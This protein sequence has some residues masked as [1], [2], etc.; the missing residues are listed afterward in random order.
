MHASKLAG[1]RQSLTTTTT[2]TKQQ[3]FN[4]NN[5]AESQRVRE[6]KQR[7]VTIAVESFFPLFRPSMSGFRP[8]L[9]RTHSKER[10][11]TNALYYLQS[12]ADEL[13]QE[14]GINT[15]LAVVAETV[16]PALCLYLLPTCY[17]QVQDAQKIRQLN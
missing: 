5:T 13:S 6:A 16:L 17:E 3:T 1:N 9:H 14:G 15:A 11:R 7:S 10:E 8:V 2:A 4:E 12:S